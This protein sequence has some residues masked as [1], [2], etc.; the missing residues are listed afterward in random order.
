MFNTNTASVPAKRS[1]FL[2]PGF[3]IGAI[4]LAFLAFFVITNWVKYNDIGVTA[5][6]SID[7]QYKANQNH[8]GQLTLKVKE[9]LGVAK[10]NNA[11]LERII[12]SSLEGRYGNDGEGAKQ[13]MLWVKENY[14]GT[15]DPSL[16]LNVQ[17]TI[18]AGRTDFQAKQ[19]LLIDK[20]AVYKTQTETVWSGFWLG[21]S[22][23]PRPTFDYK[24]YE[25]VLAEG[26]AETF[27]KKIDEGMDIQ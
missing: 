6:N 11:E 24:R 18:L 15:Y 8:L 14:P 25:P 4:L 17:Q 20:V 2:A 9:A 3:I 12:R 1:F 13:A 5:E 26:P 27:E 21:L 16:M 22:G 10:L 23:F 19:D 7:A